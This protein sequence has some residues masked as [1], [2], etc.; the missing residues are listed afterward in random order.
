MM[1]SFRSYSSLLTLVPLSL[2]LT[3]FAA[4]HGMS[5]SGRDSFDIEI[6]AYT[7]PT[8]VS[9]TQHHAIREETTLNLRDDASH[10]QVYTARS[11]PPKFNANSK[12]QGFA[13]RTPSKAGQGKDGE[14]KSYS[15]IGSYK[16]HANGEL[17]VEVFNGKDKAANLKNVQT[18]INQRFKSG[19]YVDAGMLTNLEL[20]RQGFPAVLIKPMTPIP[21]KSAG[22]FKDD[23]YLQD[24]K[25]GPKKAGL[26]AGE[27]PSY[28]LQGK[29]NG[30][31]IEVFPKSGDLSVVVKTIEKYEKLGQYVES[32]MVKAAD[33]QAQKELGSVQPMRG[34]VWKPLEQHPV[35][36]HAKDDILK[37]YTIGNKVSSGKNGEYDTYSLTKGGTQNHFLLEVFPPNGNQALGK[38]ME[39]FKKNGQLVDYGRVENAKFGKGQRG[40]IIIKVDENRAPA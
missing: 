17:V 25:I 2:F 39:N 34:V 26:K 19:Q 1:V 23:V 8:E 13:I 15:V 10:S 16:G 36:E 28:A 21:V 5:V 38:E 27:Q 9:A 20:G 31:F 32:G 33:V 22:K 4:P 11:S 30:Q 37:G 24:I 35:D 18:E 3:A 29:R 12:L 7:D 14:Y 6:R 40:A